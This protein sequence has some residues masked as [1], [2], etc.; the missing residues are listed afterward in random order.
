MLTAKSVC[1]SPC[2]VIQVCNRMK[3]IFW[4][5]P[6]Y[7]I[8][9]IVHPICGD[10]ISHNVFHYQN[11]LPQC[12]ARNQLMEHFLHSSK[13]PLRGRLVKGGRYWVKD[14]EEAP[15]KKYL[16]LRYLNA[17]KMGAKVKNYHGHTKARSRWWRQQRWLRRLRWDFSLSASSDQ[18]HCSLQHLKAQTC[19]MSIDIKVL[20][21]KCPNC[22]RNWFGTK[23]EHHIS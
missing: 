1:K 6:F 14:G 17:K 9:P 8:N 19:K 15:A 13:N 23:Y 21:W 12:L 10:N 22:N 20:P 7:Q 11:I 4:Y 3:I 2:E 18:Q 16:C 5:S